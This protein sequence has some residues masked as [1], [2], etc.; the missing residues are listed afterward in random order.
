MPRINPPRAT[1]ADLAKTE[2][3]AELI[4]GRIE[5]FPAS[6]YRPGRIA[7]RIF[8]SLDDFAGATGVGGAYSATVV[9]AIAGLRSGRESFSAD[10][11]YFLGTAPAND[12]GFLEGAPALAVEVRDEKDYGP[13]AEAAIAAKR[14]D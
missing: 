13:G 14:G 6:G 11:S 1:L 3:Q 8:R 12:M 4:G 7:G 10:V 9:Y 2:G 5:R